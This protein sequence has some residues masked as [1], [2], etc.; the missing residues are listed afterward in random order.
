[1][2]GVLLGRRL[3]NITAIDM[4]MQWMN[5]SLFRWPVILRSLV[6]S[7]CL[8]QS[9]LLHFT[10]FQ[11]TE[12]FSPNQTPAAL[13]DQLQLN[14]ACLSLTEHKEHWSQTMVTIISKL[15]KALPLIIIH[16][17]FY[18][19]HSVEFIKGFLSF[20]SDCQSIICVCV[21]LVNFNKCICTH[22]LDLL[23]FAQSKLSTYFLQLN[24]FILF[25]V[26]VFIMHNRDTLFKFLVV[27]TGHDIWITSKNRKSLA[28]TL[29]ENVHSI[30]FCYQELICAK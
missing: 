24:I 8:A 23:W 3:L 4:E 18:W 17:D 5:V 29:G 15:K 30:R 1:M 16:A 13:F 7:A 25:Y 27:L 12:C 28:C 22:C 21:Y 2:N 10:F 11:P 26:S 6:N 9:S 14:G 20:L 19:N